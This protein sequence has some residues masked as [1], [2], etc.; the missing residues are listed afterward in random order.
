M[1]I[2]TSF[3]RKLK[4]KKKNSGTYTGLKSVASKEYITSHSPV[5][6]ALIGS[7]SVTTK[8]EYHRV[9]TASQKAFRTWRTLPAPKRGEIVRQYGEELRK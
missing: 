3:L 8:S 6:G 4:V 7:V 5:D 1:K 9:V 2:D